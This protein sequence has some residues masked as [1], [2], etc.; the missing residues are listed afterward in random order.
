MDDREQVETLAYAEG[1]RHGE[2][3]AEI[4][5]AAWLAAQPVDGDEDLA[6]LYRLAEM[7]RDR[8]WRR[9]EFLS[10]VD[11]EELATDPRGSVGRHKVG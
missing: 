9:P 10:V 6:M 2:R 7:L 11:A 5:I 1:R 4:A 8:T 3:W